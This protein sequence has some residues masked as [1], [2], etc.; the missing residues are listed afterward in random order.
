LLSFAPN[1]ALSHCRD[2]DQRM[3]TLL[4]SDAN[5]AEPSDWT[6]RITGPGV[7]ESGSGDTGA[8]AEVVDG[9]TYTISESD[10]AGWVLASVQC[11]DEG[12]DSQDI[13]TD[14]PLSRQITISPNALGDITCTFTNRPADAPSADLIVE[15]VVLGD[16]SGAPTFT[17]TVTGLANWSLNSGEDTGDAYEGIEP[18]TYTIAENAPGGDWNLVGYAVVG[19]TAACPSVPTTSDVSIDVT[20]TDGESAR[21][22]VYNEASDVLQTGN[23]RLEKVNA[24]GVPIAWTMTVTG[25]SF[26]QG[27]QCIVPATGRNLDGIQPGL[28]V[29]REASIDGWSV[30]N[31][32][33]NGASQG[34]LTTVN[35]DVLPGET[36]VVR[37][38]NR[39]DVPT[40]TPTATPTQETPTPVQETPT[41]P[42]L[43]PTPTLTPT[44]EAAPGVLEIRKVIVNPEAEGASP[45]DLF[46]ASVN[47]S[48]VSFS[49]NQPASLQLDAGQ[50]TVIELLDHDDEDYCF[51]SW[52]LAENGVCPAT[53]TAALGEASVTVVSGETTVLCFYN[54]RTI[55][56]IAGEIITPVPPAAGLGLAAQ[57]ND[58]G[59]VMFLVWLGLSLVSG[60]AAIVV[61]FAGSR[62]RWTGM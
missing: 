56:E 2:G 5:G 32:I 49:V 47:G 20:L 23:I 15:K 33:V 51:V 18:G 40:P 44:P 62:R 54:T 45:D 8:S 36:T 46:E 26:A 53:A 48:V 14:G 57:S 4:K 24:A 60:G 61:A 27:Q 50:Y 37:F 35:A 16:D 3:L 9:Q 38:V 21:V 28:Y 7:D 22:C 34:A 59:N 42:A 58:T 31:V 10:E 25:P 30:V 6:M 11:V 43:T 19:L 52:A 17:G 41:P 39:L 29:V 55:E 1:G 13:E 12:Q